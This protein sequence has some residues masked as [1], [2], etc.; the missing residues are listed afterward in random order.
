[1]SWKGQLQRHIKEVVFIV[2]NKPSS[3]GLKSFLH[4]NFQQL[5]F[6]NPEISLS[7][8]ERQVEPSI[9]VRY[10]KGLER[11]SPL[12]NLT[13]VDVETKFKDLV[14]NPPSVVGGS[15]GGKT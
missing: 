13:E 4:G 9:I 8:L 6:L 5:A 2:G 15:G 3:T 11:F 7:V 1:M 10:G 12:Q 14:M